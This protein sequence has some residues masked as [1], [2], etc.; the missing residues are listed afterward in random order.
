MACPER[1]QHFGGPTLEQFILRTQT[2]E[3]VR[4]KV[5]EVLAVNVPTA[6]ALLD[7]L[8]RPAGTISFL[9]TLNDAR[10]IAR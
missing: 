5:A 10:L 3:F 8:D 7:R 4:Q 1:G 6:T 9:R 2:D